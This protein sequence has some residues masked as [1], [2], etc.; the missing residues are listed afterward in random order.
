MQ[1]GTSGVAIFRV[2]VTVETGESLCPLFVNAVSRS[3]AI[4]LARSQGLIMNGEKASVIQIEAQSHLSRFR[5]DCHW[6]IFPSWPRLQ[7]DRSQAATEGATAQRHS[8]A[9][10]RLST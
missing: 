5:I 1:R 3:A 4:D 8:M 7:A 6:L 10:P 2:I 9:R